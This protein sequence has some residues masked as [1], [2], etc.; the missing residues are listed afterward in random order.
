MSILKNIRIVLVEP[1]HPGNIGQ[2]ARAMKTM[3]LERL[4]L[5]N[6]K[7]FPCQEAFYRA[8]HADDV[9]RKANVV[10]SFQEAIADCSVVFGTSVR[11]RILAQTLLFPRDA[12]EKIIRDFH[13]EEVAIVF[14]CEQS[15]LNNEDLERCQFHIKIPSVDE[16]SSLNLAAAVQVMAYE[17]RMASLSSLQQNRLSNQ[18]SPLATTED[19][20]KFYQHLRETMIDIEFLDLR[21]PRKM[22]KR[23]R[24]IYNRAILDKEDL[25][26]LRGMLTAVQRNVL[27]RQK[28]KDC[29]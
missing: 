27:K 16:Y 18:R 22:I 6:P 28:G 14:G 4:F 29:L 5:V 17:I 9:V 12:A 21:H 19:M 20:E 10:A 26:L 11:E 3:G 24:Q 1:Q 15:G 25:N 13:Q 23:F 2:A 8:A 7:N